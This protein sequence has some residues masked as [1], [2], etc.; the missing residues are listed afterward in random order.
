MDRKYCPKC[1]RKTEALKCG[2]GEVGSLSGNARYRCKL[3][4]TEHYG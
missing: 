2:F 3:C 4:G 1:K